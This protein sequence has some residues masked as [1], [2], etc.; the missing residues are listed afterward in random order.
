MTEPVLMWNPLDSFEDEWEDL[1]ADLTTLLCK[2]NIGGK[3]YCEVRNFGWQKKNGFKSFE[4]RIGSSFLG[5]ILLSKT[6]TRC[7]PAMSPG[8]R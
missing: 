6:A 3:W 5:K 2:I 4:T 1:V 8:A 7:P